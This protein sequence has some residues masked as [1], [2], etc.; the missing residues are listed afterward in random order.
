MKICLRFLFIYSLLSLNSQAL[1]WLM[2]PKWS[3]SSAERCKYDGI[4]TQQQRQQKTT[5]TMTTG[6]TSV[7][8]E[9]TD[10]PAE[11][12]LMMIIHRTVQNGENEYSQTISTELNRPSANLITL[13]AASMDWDGCQYAFFDGTAKKNNLQLFNT[14]PGILPQKLTLRPPANTLFYDELIPWLRRCLQTVQPDDSLQ[15]ANSLLNKPLSYQLIPARVL[16]V[17]TGKENDQPTRTVTLVIGNA[18]E[19]FTF[20]DYALRPLLHWESS[21]GDY[22]HL[23]NYSFIDSPYSGN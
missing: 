22:L 17:T 16:S 7:N 4:I 1:D 14:T 9:N 5:V 2:L 23:R 6:L 15:V 3:E 19:S 12:N 18:Q 11:L 8:N 20:A 10:K 21:N 13:T